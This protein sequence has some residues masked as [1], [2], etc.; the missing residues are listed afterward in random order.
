MKPTAFEKIV[1]SKGDKSKIE[2]YTEQAEE[3]NS[4]KSINFLQ[5]R[6]N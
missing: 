2:K 3:I 6:G 4:E 1:H 5:N